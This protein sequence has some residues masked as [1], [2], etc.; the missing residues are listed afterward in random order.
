MQ[1]IVMRQGFALINI[2]A[3]ITP[4]HN[5]QPNGNAPF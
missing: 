5:L 1:K 4:Y 3:E 2:G